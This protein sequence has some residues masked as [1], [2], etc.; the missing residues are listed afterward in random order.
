MTRPNADLMKHLNTVADAAAQLSLDIKRLGNVIS[1]EFERAAFELHIEALIS[2]PDAL[3]EDCYATL[4]NARERL[5][6]FGEPVI[7][8]P[9]NVN[10]DTH[11]DLLPD[12]LIDKRFRTL[13]NLV[14]K[15][16]VELRKQNPDEAA[17]MEEPEILPPVA[18]EAMLED[19]AASLQTAQE[20]TQDVEEQ[21]R[22]ELEPDNYV[23]DDTFLRQLVSGK[24]AFLIA[25][26]ELAQKI[27]IKH[28]IENAKR[29]VG[30]F[31]E[32]LHISV[33]NLR[34]A[35]KGAQ[36]LITDT[37]PVLQESVEFA[38]S[39]MSKLTRDWRVPPK[40]SPTSPPPV[41]PEIQEAAEREAER[42]LENN[43]PVPRE[44]AVNVR[45]VSLDLSAF[46]SPELLAM[47]PYLSNLHIYGTK[48]RDVSVLKDMK[49]L[50]G[51]CLDKTQIS[52]IS[53]LE[54]MTQLQELYLDD[55]QINDF[56]VLE[57]MTQL[58]ELD[59]H[60]TQVSDISVL[61]G[62]TQLQ[63]LN[64]NDTQVSDISVLE[65]MTQLQNLWLNH[66]QVTDWSPVDHLDND[67]V[68]GRPGDWVRKKGGGV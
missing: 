55:A 41:D 42:L 20:K 32:N 47:I 25:R 40:P 60:G 56:S 50:Q 12:G 4:I 10:E 39:K 23:S 19:T 27:K 46:N 22:K 44:M 58:Q 5:L 66:T 11:D 29:N 62:M 36:R 61:K 30:N 8:T 24:I 35:A 34:P 57:G 67:V 18:N 65:G 49:Q 48:I 1:G 64:L 15:A 38:L 21:A 37:I 6:G 51:L 43:Q 31:A 59:L 52:D 3:A 9:D 33:R 53:G 14:G 16:L 7:V 17:A 68:R 28:L 63:S 54:G 26:S 13:D 45:N 2:L